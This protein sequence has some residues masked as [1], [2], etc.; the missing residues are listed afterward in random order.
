MIPQLPK[1]ALI[2]LAQPDTPWRVALEGEGAADA[3]SPGRDL[4]A[5]ITN[6]CLQPCLSLFIS[7]ENGMIPNPLCKNTD[8]FFYFGALIAI[9][10]ISKL[11]QPFRLTRF[12]WQYIVNR[13]L[14]IDHLREIGPD[15]CKFLTIV[16]T[17]DDPESFNKMKLTWVVQSFNG[18]VDELFDGGIKKNVEFENHLQY[19]EMYESFRISGLRKPLEKIVGGI[20]VFFG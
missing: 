15:Y 10:I 14:T 18:I 2:K 3:G 9:S 6:E 5:E 11:L 13:S 4:F 17:M 19:C 20:S 12:V 7:S 1:S 16:K 8:R